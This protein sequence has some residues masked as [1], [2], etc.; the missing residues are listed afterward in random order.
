VPALRSK[1]S[2]QLSSPAP[3]STSSC[4]C[5]TVATSWGV[6]SKV[7]GEAPTGTMLCT[8]TLS[9][10]TPRTNDSRIEI[11]VTT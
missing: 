2:S 6:G 5:A 7:S 1:R 10:P 4:A 11:V 9:P 8:R 3:F